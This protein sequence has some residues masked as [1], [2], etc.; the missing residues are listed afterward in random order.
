LADE[1]KLLKLVDMHGAPVCYVHEAEARE[2]IQLGHAFVFQTRNGTASKNRGL[3]LKVPLSV[4]NGTDSPERSLS[5]TNYCGTRFIFRA[6]ISTDATNF[7]SFRFKKV[8]PLESPDAA[9]LR[10]MGKLPEW[11][12]PIRDANDSSDT[13][14]GSRHSR[15]R[16]ADGRVPNTSQSRPHTAD[17]AA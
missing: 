9:L 2:L 13:F 8:H 6:K 16:S 7:Y 4:V 14:A 17:R 5:I 11:P 15:V 1:P 12:P 3:K 10:M